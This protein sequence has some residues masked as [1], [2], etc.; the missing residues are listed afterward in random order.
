MSRENKLLK[1]GVC[2][3]AFQILQKEIYADHLDRMKVVKL[4]TF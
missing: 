4:N 2:V 3:Y 1:R